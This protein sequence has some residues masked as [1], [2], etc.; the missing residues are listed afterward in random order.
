MMPPVS[1]LSRSR[2]EIR[3]HNAFQRS[4]PRLYIYSKFTGVVVRMPRD[5]VL[6]ALCLLPTC[7]SYL[8]ICTSQVKRVHCGHHIIIPTF[9]SSHTWG[10]FKGATGRKIPMLLIPHLRLGQ[11]EAEVVA[12][13][14]GCATGCHHCSPLAFNG[15]V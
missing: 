9:G 8:G 4:T 3:R 13:P 10:E 2:P 15:V 12:V 7:V 6:D 14:Q 11:I 1:S 5:L